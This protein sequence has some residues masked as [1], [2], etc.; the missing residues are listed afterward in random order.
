MQEELEQFTRNE[1]WDLMPR[2]KY[3]NVNRTTEFELWYTHDSTA[4]L[5]GCCDAEADYIVV[6]IIYSQLIW[7]KNMLKDYG[8]SQDGA[9]S[10]VAFY[11]D[12]LSAINISKNPVQHS[13]TI[14][15][16]IRHHFIK[17]LVEDRVIETKQIP[18]ERQLA[19]ILTQDLDASHFEA[20]RSSLGLCI[21][22]IV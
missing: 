14:H 8:V 3:A 11:Y 13:R 22:S 2:L 19:D 4:G 7:I 18:I 10:G 6:G 17:S 20:L 21:P 16:N 12:D 1:V 15:I 9:P 5:K